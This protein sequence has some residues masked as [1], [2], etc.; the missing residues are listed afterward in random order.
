MICSTLEQKGFHHLT[1]PKCREFFERDVLRKTRTRPLW[2]TQH[3]LWRVRPRLYWSILRISFW[4]LTSYNVG[5]T[6]RAIY[7]TFAISM[8]TTGRSCYGPIW[9]GLALYLLQLQSWRN[10][11]T[12]KGKAMYCAIT[13]LLIQCFPNCV[14]RHTGVPLKRL[15]C[16]A[17]ALCFDK[18][19]FML[20]HLRYKVCEE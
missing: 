17:N 4:Q 14:P 7:T 3:P 1:S 2:R 5:L 12:W 15:K 16:S 11:Y 6:G 19:I 18:T 10:P 9:R 8:G 20:H 13:F